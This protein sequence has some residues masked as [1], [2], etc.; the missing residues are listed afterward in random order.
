[1]LAITASCDSPRCSERHVLVYLRNWILPTGGKAYL[2]NIKPVA[3][4]GIY[5]VY[6][7]LLERTVRGFISA[8][9]WS[10][11][12]SDLSPVTG[13]TL[14]YEGMKTALLC[15]C[16]ILVSSSSM[17]TQSCMATQSWRDNRARLCFV[18]SEDNG[19]M[20]ILQ[21]WI[22]VADYDVPVIGG[23]AVCL[24][25]H[26]GSEELIV[27]STI[28]YDPNSRNTRACKSKALKLELAADEDR[29]FTIEPATNRDRYTCGWRIQQTHSSH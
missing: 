15:L 5:H 2:H 25:V 14:Y 28:P 12:N 16:G 24:Y 9:S 10:E 17:A 7:F 21:S 27:T 20:N 26:P 13:T 4:H 23:Q 29:T 3:F 1:V 11:C 18:R 8:F 19:A 6:R 22:R